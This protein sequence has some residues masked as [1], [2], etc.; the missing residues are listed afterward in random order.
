MVSGGLE[1]ATKNN[2]KPYLVVMKVH[3]EWMVRSVFRGSKWEMVGGSKMDRDQWYQ[4]RRAVRRQHPEDGETTDRVR[5]YIWQPGI[6][7][8]C[9]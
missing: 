7:T 1:G 4:Q 5:K 6:I 2:G 9:Q 8:V 3:T